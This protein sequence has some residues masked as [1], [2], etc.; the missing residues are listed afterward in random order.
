MTKDR[1]RRAQEEIS[2]LLPAKTT[3]IVDTSA[4]QDVRSRLAELMHEHAPSE[5][6]RPV[7][8]RRTR[9]EENDNSA[10]GNFN[11]QLQ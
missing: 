9:V 7:L 10:D 2:T 5:G 1:I 6:G 8:H 11:L 3:Y 4:F